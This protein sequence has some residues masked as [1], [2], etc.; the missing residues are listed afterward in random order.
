MITSV[1]TPPQDSAGSSVDRNSVRRNASGTHGTG[2]LYNLQV[3]RGIAALLVVW[4]HAREVLPSGLLPS[5]LPAGFAGVDIFFVISGFVMIHTTRGSSVGGYIFFVRRFFRVAP[6]Y[7]IF[8][9]ITV[10]LWWLSPQL[11]KSTEVD[12]GP[13]IK[14]ILFIP[15]EKT[16]HRIYPLYFVGWTLNYEMFFYLLF[17]IS[18]TISH[19][20]KF[21]ISSAVIILLVLFG[22]KV[23]GLEYGVS[24]YTYTRPIMLDFLMG[25]S[26]AKIFPYIYENKT[27]WRMGFLIILLGGIIGLFGISVAFPN[28]QIIAPAT[29]T[30]L[31]FGVPAT[32]IV[33]GAIGLE[34]HNFRIQNRILLNIGASSYSLY[35]LHFFV[36]GVGIAVANRLHLS[37]ELRAIAVPVLIASACAASIVFHRFVELPLGRFLKRYEPKITVRA[38]PGNG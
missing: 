20:Y 34:R 31:I 16:L 19:R 30:F 18:L 37:V 1:S 7:Y 29:D 28:H 17:S 12:A 11:L 3:L 23:R 38:M 15:Y 6:I 10:F 13:F 5:W 27:D 8:V 2:L 4:A 25:M 26:L 21:L 9:M 35:L 14:T 24:I 22:L 32:M 36:V 33:L